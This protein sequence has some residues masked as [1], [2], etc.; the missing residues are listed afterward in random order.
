MGPKHWS[1]DFDEREEICHNGQARFMYVCMYVCMYAVGVFKTIIEGEI[2]TIQS[3][4]SHPYDME[5]DESE[6]L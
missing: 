4:T 1:Q 3:R 2:V 6:A 5:L